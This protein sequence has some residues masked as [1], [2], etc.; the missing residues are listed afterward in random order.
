MVKINLVKKRFSVFKKIDQLRNVAVVLT[1]ITIVG[2]LGQ[3]FFLVGRIVIL[4]NKIDQLSADVSST[5]QRMS[6]RQDDILKYAPVK[7][8]LQVMNKEI[9]EKYR[10][11]DY[12]LE[13]GSWLSDEVEL[14]GVNFANKEDIRFTIRVKGV[15]SYRRVEADLSEID[16]GGDNGFF[17]L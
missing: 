12:L 7:F 10:Y 14:V 1:V 17:Q 11:K 8:I 6:G 5:Q 3:V 13:I 2:F 4:N 16:F 15:D 9:D